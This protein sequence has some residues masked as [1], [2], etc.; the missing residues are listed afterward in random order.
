MTFRAHC[1]TLR[2]TLPSALPC[3][4]TVPPCAPLSH[5]H[6]AAMRTAVF[7]PTHR[8]ALRN[9]LPCA[10][11]FLPQGPACTKPYPEHRHPLRTA[12]RSA[13]SCAAPCPTRCFNLQETYSSTVKK[14]EGV[15]PVHRFCDVAQSIAM[16]K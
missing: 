3:P 6:Y 10:P 2:Y 9:M 11:P 5:T 14:M 15:Y 12:L 8:S 13:L 7:C 1:F 4:S 16:P